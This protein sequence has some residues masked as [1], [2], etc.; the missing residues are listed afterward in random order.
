[1]KVIAYLI[2]FVL[3]TTGANIFLK[4]GVS[5]KEL[6]SFE[7]FEIFLSWRVL[8]GLGLFGIAMMLWLVILRQLSLSV[9]Q[10][11]SAA[12]FVAVIIASKI[13]LAEP[14]ASQQ[15]IGMGLIAIGIAV[16]GWGQ[17]G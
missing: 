7:F 2:L 12:Q 14:I 8:L 3:C 10:S 16:V 6:R 11:F 9:A 5:G 1:M 13:I 4:L 15:W 17:V